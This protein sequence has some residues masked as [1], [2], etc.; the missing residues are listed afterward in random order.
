ML[1]VS[2][3]EI[4]IRVPVIDNSGDHDSKISESDYGHIERA[5][6]MLE[7]A[8]CLN[9]GVSRNDEGA[10]NFLGPP[11]I[12]PGTNKPAW[13]EKAHNPPVSQID[14]VIDTTVRDSEMRSS[15]PEMSLEELR[16]RPERT[17]SPPRPRANSWRHGDG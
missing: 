5:L 16:E 17:R 3:K 2:F 1:K 8:G 12:I 7:D 11:P 15:V 14:P 13:R 10:V 6:S 4:T 9:E